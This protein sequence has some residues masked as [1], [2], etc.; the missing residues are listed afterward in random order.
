[1]AEAEK[2]QAPQTDTKEA[3]KADASKTQAAGKTGILTYIIMAVVVFAMAGSGF[4]MGRIF[5]GGNGQPQTTEAG[6]APKKEAKAE[7]KS[8]HGGG[9]GAKKEEK[10]SGHGGGHGGGHGAKEEKSSAPTISSP[11]DTWYYG[12]L[13]SVVVNPDEPGATRYVRVGLNLEFGGDFSTEEA[14][15]L[16]T[17]KK[18]LLINWLNLYFKS[19]SLSQMQNDRDMKR[20][21]TQICDAFNEVL[22]P[23]QKPKIKKIL[24][25]EFNIQ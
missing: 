19:L 24:I 16:I 11:N 9:H 4:F 14:G 13:E 12:E 10:K 17:S 18:P 5:A 15:E 8:G 1:M 3:P 23:E 20:I 21:L 2:N 6:A 22:F 7:K 25:R